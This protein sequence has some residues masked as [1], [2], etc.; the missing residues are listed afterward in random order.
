MRHPDI[1]TAARSRRPRRGRIAWNDPHAAVHGPFGASATRGLIPPQR[2]GAPFEPEVTGVG[3]GGGLS[4]R[5]GGE[6]S[7]AASPEPASAAPSRKGEGVE[8]GGIDGWPATG[9]C[10]LG[11]RTAG[12]R[13]RPRRHRRGLLLHPRR[14]GLRLGVQP[15]ERRRR[16]LPDVLAMVVDRGPLERDGRVG[17]ADLPQ[18]DRRGDADILEIVVLEHM[19]QRRHGAGVSQ[20]AQGIG[21]LLA[22]AR[23]AGSGGA[24]TS[25]P[26]GR[27][28]AGPGAPGRPGPPG[29]RRPS[30][31]RHTAAA[32]AA[33]AARRTRNSASGRPSARI[34]RPGPAARSP[35]DA[36]RSTAAA[37]TA[38]GSG[39]ASPPAIAG[40]APVAR[41]SRPA[42]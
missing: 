13:P 34:R 23:V 2:S 25:G 37:A 15:L 5:C 35:G 4:S 36:G 42:A 39:H 3:G 24:G 26:P 38:R 28:A 12:G 16:R 14:Q 19:D 41:R 30:R 33:A 1:S 29:R 17:P 9:G 8:A 27:E 20:P 18:R 7:G 40:S 10:G 31:R 22:A 32:H 11:G 6:S 21:G